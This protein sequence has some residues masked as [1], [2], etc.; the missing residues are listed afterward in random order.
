[1]KYLQNFALAVSAGTFGR[2]SYCGGEVWLIN[3][4]AN[5]VWVLR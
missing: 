4:A 3:G 2:L 5:N 1:M